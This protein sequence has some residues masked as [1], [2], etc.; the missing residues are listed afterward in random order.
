MLEVWQATDQIKWTND[1]EVV[2]NR[3]FLQLH[4]KTV[5]HLKKGIAVDRICSNQLISGYFIRG[6]DVFL[7]HSTSFIFSTITVSKKYTF[8][9]KPAYTYTYQKTC[10][11]TI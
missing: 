10:L 2:H 5:Y 1:S 8:L 7:F 6:T 4:N 11:L 9:V 3:S